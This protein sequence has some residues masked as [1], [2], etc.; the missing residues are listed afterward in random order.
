[1]L[2][3]FILILIMAGGIG[4]ALNSFILQKSWRKCAEY[5]TFHNVKK[6]AF[7]GALCLA[8]IVESCVSDS[9]FAAQIM[10]NIF[11]HHLD[12]WNAM[13]KS[14]SYAKGLNRDLLVENL[15]CIIRKQDDDFKL[16]FIPLIVKS[17]TAAEFMWNEKQQG[18]KPSDYL[19]SLLSYSVAA[20]EKADAYRVLGLEPGASPERV[21]KAHRKL[22]AKYHPDSGNSTNLEMFMKIQTAYEMLT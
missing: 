9:F 22:A 19:K 2:P 3:C 11:G 6:E 14:V 21:R 4:Y 20:D 13:T 18:E 16:K 15:I 1:M 7:P 8:A 5:G 12:E 10:K 17:L